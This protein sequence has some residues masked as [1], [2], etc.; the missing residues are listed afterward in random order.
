[1]SKPYISDAVIRRLPR[2]YRHLNDLQN[3][4]VVRISSGALGTRMGLTPA[5]IRQDLH[6]FGDFGQQGYGYHI[7]TLRHEIGQI[8]GVDH[9]RRIIVLGAGHLGHV[10]LK[11]FD[12][13]A[14]GFQ[15]DA[16][17]DIQPELF[18]AVIGNVTVRP[19]TELADYVALHHPDVAALTV[20]PQEAQSLTDKL[21]AMGLRG[22]WN[23]TNVELTSPV[24]GVAFEDV[25]L[26]DTLLKLNYRISHS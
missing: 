7:P 17:F 21:V 9:V 3:Q 16:A 12:F 13:Q 8:L 2:Y 19:M 18:G 10:L 5:Q 22:I 24:P 6:C 4:G 26:M 1:M 15:I 23:F 20:P 25:H 14:A 11:N